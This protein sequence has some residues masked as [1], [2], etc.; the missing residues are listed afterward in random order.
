MTLILKKNLV[1]IFCLSYFLE[2]NAWWQSYSESQKRKGISVVKLKWGWGECVQ[3]IWSRCLRVPASVSRAGLFHYGGNQGASYW[4][5]HTMG[6][7]VSCHAPLRSTIPL[8]PIPFKNTDNRR[9][10]SARVRHSMT[11]AQWI[12]TFHLRNFNGLRAD[13]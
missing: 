4:L 3:E 8:K 5:V 6:M 11:R 10:K 9:E 1:L 7:S 12:P 2:K 13:P